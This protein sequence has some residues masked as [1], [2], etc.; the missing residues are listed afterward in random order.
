M[1]PYQFA[2]N[3]PI[4]GIDLDGLEYATFTITSINGYVMSI[5]VEKDYELKNLDTKGPGIQY[6]YVNQTNGYGK[7][8]SGKM[9]AAEWLRIRESDPSYSSRIVEEKEVTK[10]VKNMYGIYQG[11]DNP[12]LPKLGEPV[13][14]VYDNYDLK[15]I[16]ETDANAK[17]HDKDYDVNKLTGMGGVM[18]PKSTPANKAYIERATETIKK[19]NGGIDIVTGKPITKEAVDAAKD[20]KKFF[21]AVEKAKKIIN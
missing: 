4:D 14:K 16:N 19:E 21:K 6:N 8:S 11:P 7:I 9:S 1:T 3:R 13:D 17:Q 15:P 10:F 12:K 5:K 2:S 18:D 20:G